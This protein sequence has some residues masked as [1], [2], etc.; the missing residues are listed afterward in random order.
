MSTV[1]KVA[2]NAAA[3]A[4][5][6]ALLSV[7]GLVS[8]G[9][10][11]R[12]LGVDH[13]GS[14]TTA[15]AF[16]TALSP[17]TDIGVSTIAARELAKHPEQKDRLVGSVMTLALAMSLV[18]LVVGFGAI[19][20]LFPGGDGRDVRGAVHL[21]LLAPLLT[22]AP[23][24]AAYA[25]FV[26]TQRAWVGVAA[27]VGGSLLTLTL[28]VLTWVLD[29]GYYG[30]VAAYA[31]TATGY[32]AVTLIL[33]AGKIRL[34]FEFDRALLRRL[35]VWAVPIGLNTVVGA[36]YVRVPVIA[37]GLL[38]TKA[39]VALYGVGFKLFDALL[40]VPWFVTITL[41]PEFARLAQ[42][43]DRL[44]ALVQRATGLMLYIVI[45]LLI[46]L[47]V[48]ADEIA[49]VAGGAAFEGAATV[50]R[51]LSVGVA[52]TFMS[53]VL[54]QAM[55]ALNR[56]SQLL[57]VVIAALVVNVGLCSALIPPLGATGAALAFLLS[58][59]AAVFGMLRLYGQTGAMPRPVL[60]PALLVAAMVMAGVAMLK[61]PLGDRL[62]SPALVAIL[63]GAAAVGAYVACL[64]ALN[65]MP[66]EIDDGIVRPIR[67]RLRAHARRRSPPS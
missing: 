26:A 35:L 51:I 46:G 52:A 62:H 11:T 13:Y 44:D 12:Y 23:A 5:G 14:L 29:W 40:A 53:G 59:V 37:L 34:R 25:Y 61:F 28:L 60:R 42:Q 49:K 67:A 31:G 1:R 55:V 65:A 18:V 20:L 22:G 66:T 19:Q 4:V 38:S 32:A 27:S 30:V 43:R 54:G 36:F 6:R 3:A 7:S 17:L 2:V 15:T 21:M 24:A 58:E 41:M 63:G 64:Y 8:V 39:E 50:I 10:A 9:L 16:V 33:A 56:Q 45:P 47:V 48:F 57:M